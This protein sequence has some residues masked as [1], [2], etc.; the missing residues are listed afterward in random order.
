M[1]SCTAAGQRIRTYQHFWIRRL[2]LLL[3][4]HKKVIVNPNPFIDSY[5]SSA[6]QTTQ[7]PWNIAMIVSEGLLFSPAESLFTKR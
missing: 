5:S 4:M 1:N 7:L 6:W 3:N 2:F